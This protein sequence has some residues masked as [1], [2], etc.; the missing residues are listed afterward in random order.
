MLKRDK[1]DEGKD[2]WMPGEIRQL[3]NTIAQHET[4]FGLKSF[5]SGVA[6]GSKNIH[7]RTG[8]GDRAGDGG[9]GG[10]SATE[11]AELKAHG[12]EVKPEIIVDSSGVILEP[13]FKVWQL[14]HTLSDGTLTPPTDAI[15]YSHCLPTFGPKP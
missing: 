6:R 2:T 8:D 15:P 5:T 3:I 12:Y 1:K 14:F 7:T 4:K 13:L 11:S 10:A 9:G